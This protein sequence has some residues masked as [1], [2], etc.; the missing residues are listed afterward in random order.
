MPTQSKAACLPSDKR[1]APNFFR[2]LNFYVFVGKQAGGQIPV[3]GIGQRGVLICFGDA[4]RKKP[5]CVGIPW[6]ISP[7]AL[8]LTW[9]LRK[10]IE[11]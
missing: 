6:G 10:L 9:F 5:F 2:N 11:S 1:K 3:N 8:R 7:N 4:K